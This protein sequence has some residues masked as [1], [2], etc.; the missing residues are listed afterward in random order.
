MFITNH[1]IAGSVIG[2]AAPN[3]PVAFTAGFVSHFVLDAIPHY[4]S[5]NWKRAGVI[6]GL[7]GLTVAATIYT[8]TPAHRR[9]RL[10]A[11]VT[12]ACLPDS[13][14]PLLMFTGSKRH[15]QWFQKFHG[16]IQNEQKKFWRN[17]AAF[18]AIGTAVVTDLIGGAN[19]E[20]NFLSMSHSNNCPD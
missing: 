6:D 11:G 18:A 19:T 8:K 2:L 12:G 1:V 20:K 13:D 16:M 5:S 15:P 9:G 10:V 3:V 4:Y 7:I 17:E 14:K